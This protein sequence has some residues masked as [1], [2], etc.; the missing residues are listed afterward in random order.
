MW[1]S[2]FLENKDQLMLRSVETA[3]AGI[4]L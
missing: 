2:P 4:G 3:H 1:R